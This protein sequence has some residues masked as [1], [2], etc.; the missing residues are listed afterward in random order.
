[1]IKKQT[2][3]IYFYCL[4]FCWFPVTCLSAFFCVGIV[5]KSETRNCWQINLTH[6]LLN[7]LNEI[8]HLPFLE[9]FII[10]FWGAYQDENLKLIFQQY[11][12]WSDQTDVQTGLALYWWQ[13]LIWLLRSSRIRVKSTDINHIT[14][15][16]IYIYNN[17]S[18]TNL[19][20]FWI[21]LY[22]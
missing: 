18:K 5:M 21:K 8:I 4:W 9:L 10:I 3:K 6:N 12:A 11:R 17:K 13:R 1:M 2:E 19:F 22:S 14:Q 20:S 15:P 7:L 16:I